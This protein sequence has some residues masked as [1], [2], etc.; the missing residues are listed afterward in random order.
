MSDKK[1][2]LKQVRKNQRS[3]LN[4]DFDSF[5]SELTNYG[6]SFFSDKISDFGTQG[7]AGMFVEMAAYIG[8]NMSYYMDHQ[9]NELDIVTAVESQNIERLV[10]SAGVKIQG[11]AP[12]TCNVDF[13]V[14]VEA[15]NTSVSGVVTTIPDSIYCPIIRAGTI[16]SSTAGVKF[17]LMEDLNF[18]KKNEAGNIVAEYSPM[19]TDS[20]GVPKSFALKLSGR[21]T[22]G[23]TLS[24]SFSIKD[25]FSP[26]LTL[27]LSGPNI[28]EIVSVKDSS[29]NEYY[30]VDALTQD[31]VYK[32]V[33]NKSYDSDKVSESIE[34]QPAPY[35]FIKSTS[36][37]TGKTTLR[38]GGG[39]ALSTDDDI[40]P[41]PSEL[42]IPLYGKRRTISRFTID[43]NALL[44]TRT[45]G[46]A[47]RNTTITVRYRSGG[48]LLHNVASESIKTISTLITKFSSEVPSSKKATIRASASCRNAEPASGGESAPTLNE[49]KSTALA[50]R[51]SQS[52]IVTKP[53]LVARIYTMP[54]KF[55]RV[56]RVGVRDNPN[57][58]LASVISII[59][60]DT[61]GKLRVSSD[62]LKENLKTYLNEYRLI[63]DA[64]DIVDAS[65]VNLKIQYS[66]VIDASSNTSLVLQNINLKLKNYMSIENWQ[67]DQPVLTSDLINLIINS[68][69]VIS[70]VTFQVLNISGTVDGREYSRESFSV[71]AN[72]DRGMIIP[73]LGSIVEIKYPEDDIIGIA[74]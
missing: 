49:L 64:Y 57:N 45:L 5:R 65:V 18:A 28:S 69:G 10:R 39:D 2:K 54:S 61:S 35:R 11:A 56:F 17:E 26:F 43:P 51:N 12:A 21:C 23:L 34:V 29:G 63:S 31:T 70:L 44:Q 47:P 73:P 25:S 24:E 27:S 19:K 59:S 4:R 42:S 67:I 62:T 74:R 66:V 1:N 9:F 3:Y 15:T 36:R 71:T 68:P 60:R 48:G 16:L 13:Y 55:G 32:R 22:S 50:F 40:M 37:N 33:I 6:R 38:F 20:S 52:R 7:L 8:D 58:P 72:T 30:E 41:D 14:E 53:D 46:I